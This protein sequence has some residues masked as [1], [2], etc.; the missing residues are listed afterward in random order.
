VRIEWNPPVLPVLCVASG[1]SDLVPFPIHVPVLNAQ[2][3][4]LPA[5]CL[6]GADYAIVHRGADVLVVGTVHH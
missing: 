1:N 4:A 2:H 5:A 3:L 6:E